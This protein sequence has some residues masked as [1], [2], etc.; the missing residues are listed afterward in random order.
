MIRLIQR[1]LIIPRGDTGSFTIPVI[2][3]S[4]ENVAVFTIFDDLT[5][6]RLFQKK[7]TSEGDVLNIAFTHNETVNLKPG[8]Y[9]WDIKYYS[10]PLFVEDELVGGDEVDSYYAGYSLPVCEIRPTGDDYLIS[11]DAPSGTLAPDQLDIITNAITALNEAV[12]KTQ[13]NVE[14]YPVIRDETWYVW[15]AES[16]DYVS[17][18]V[19]ANG[20]VGNG[21]ASAVLNDDYSLT[22]NFTDGTSFT[23]SS[24]RGETGN[25]IDD[26]VLNSDFTLTIIYTDGERYTTP[27]I[28]GPVGPTPQFSIGTVQ[29]GSNAAA[30]I[31]G[32]AENPVLNLTLPN[33]N[34]PT[35]VS[36][37][38]NDA[39]YL[40]EHQDLSGYVQKTDYATTS[41]AGVV[42]V[43]TDY[44]LQM[45]NDGFLRTRS[46]SQAMI[47]AGENNVNQIAPMFQHASTFYGL[48]KAAG[49]T[50]QSQ[51]SNAVGT[52][53]DAAKAA[54]QTMLDVPSN[55]DIPTQVSELTNDAGYL[56]TE[57]DPTVPAWA[58][59]ATK[60]IYTA[61]EVGA[62]TVAEMNEAI[63]NINTMKIHICAQAEYDA[64]TGVP[65]LQNP[66]TQT[67][68]LV[69]GG[70]GSNLFIEWAYVND[71]WERF[72]SA[73]VDLSNYVTFSDIATRDNAGI[74]KYKNE[75][76]LYITND[77][78]AAVYYAPQS[79]IKR[80]TE[81]Y[82][83][84]VPANQHQSIFY[85]LAKAA[86]DTTQSTSSNAVGIYTAEA[87]AAIQQMLGVS[88]LIATAE[89][90]LVASKAYAIG[91]VFTANGKLY[92]VT[93]AIAANDAIVLQ[94]NGETISGANAV[95]TNVGEGFV[96]FTDYAT[97]NTAGVMKVNPTYG[98][99]LV[100]GTLSLS[101][102][103]LPEI[104]KPGASTSIMLTPYVQHASAF[105]GLAKA[106]GADEKNSTL[107]VGQYTDTAKSAIQAML[108]LDAS[109]IAEQ[110]EI[111]LV[112]TVAGTA[113]TITG[114]PNTR[115][116]C[117][118]VTS[119]SITPPEA[120]SIDVIFT[121][122]STTAVL[123]L[124]STVK[125]PS[126]FD[127]TSLETDTIYEVLITDGIYGS[128]MTW[129]A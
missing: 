23:T 27:S 43:S 114:Q 124:P 91:D 83:P 59:A 36:E 21:I 12:E 98:I 100:N 113:V 57:T 40:T 45:T 103:T 82:R 93:T 15:D 108:G 78:Y 6:T 128:V 54:I 48:A 28:R 64:E 58:K 72:G 61:A 4:S 96:K 55:A 46:A 75:Y 25:G 69:P 9:L 1:R 68:Y 122:G 112:E 121:S 51:S 5:H 95:E 38:E 105:Y 47:K 80:G 7:L 70:E 10:N 41:E 85:G 56:T 86:G 119:I 16:N 116:I 89:N 81:G 76:G 39:G 18:E 29:E 127:E 118:E 26:I 92:K 123:T 79:A 73:D 67:F 44:G 62:P 13:T 33:A 32:T 30:S 50:T 94:N 65:T 71:A 102:A 31:T 20:I 37:L 87:K 129:V 77:G 17:T 120:G 74:A 111:P 99:S 34:V 11:D 106:A 35:R 125:M 24:I 117:G 66:D 49:D 2:K 88:D 60:P 84:I 22:L 8:K 115:Y 63:A 3:P 104:V 42:K 107:P 90:N 53:T 19:S 109:S 126:W 101:R 97:A 110:I 52:Y 14:H